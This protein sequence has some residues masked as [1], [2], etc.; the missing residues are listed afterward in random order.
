MC[1]TAIRKLNN[2]NQVVAMWNFGKYKTIVV[3]IALF[4]LLDASVLILNFYIS[5][6]ISDDAVGVN[7][8]GRQRMLSQ[9]MV[10]SL[11]DIE[12]L[13]DQ[14]DLSIKALTELDSTVNLFDKT[15]DAFENG[16]VTTDPSSNQVKISKVTDRKGRE[17][18]EK[19]RKLWTPYEKTLTPLIQNIKENG[20]TFD[21]QEPIEYARS[22]NL[23]LLKY[24]NDLTV[25]LENV[26]SSKAT[27]LR[28][29]QTIGISLAILN[30]FIIMFHF[31]KQLRESDKKIDA[32]RKETTEI[33]GTVNEGL[34]LLDQ[35]LKI[36]SQHSTQLIE[37]FNRKRFEGVSFEELLRDIVTSKTLETSKRFINLFYRED[38]NSSLIKDLNPL[39]KV[40]LSFVSEEGNYITKFFSFSFSRVYDIENKITS[41]LTTVV[42]ITEKV[43]L[44]KELAH[45]QKASEQQ[46]ELLTDIL[47]TDSN[48]VNS[49]LSRCFTEYKNINT[50]LKRT[51]RTKESL[52]QNLDKTFTIL[53]GIK[54][55]AGALGLEGFTNIIHK[56]ED[57]IRSLQDLKELN[58]NDLLPLIV[59]FESLIRYTE[60]IQHLTG[61]LKGFS[62]HN[63][64][65]PHEA[66][67]SN[68]KP[69]YYLTDFCKRIAQDN[70]KSVQ[71][72]T[73]GM[74][75]TPIDDSLNDNITTI[76]TQCIRNSI[77]H[78][79]ETPEE[80]HKLGK[81]EQGR[82]DVNLATLEN[83]I[84]EL[85]ISDDG[86]GFDFDGI[87][88]K[89]K[90]TGQ[91]PEEVID[92]WDK[93][94]LVSV[95]FNNGFSTADELTNDAGRG[96]G[97]NV[98]REKIRD[99]D[100]KIFLSS[101]KNSYS[102]L[103]ITMPYKINSQKVA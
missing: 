79:I 15:L 97:M 68:E 34:F 90:K 83:D 94:K 58:G 10:K 14:P 9:R 6:E 28:I 51:A 47:N 72:V 103:I 4:L 35:D 25:A 93:K 19:A 7:L 2:A 88:N 98:I 70:N 22:N 80:R 99:I 65:S 61:K 86:K 73:S 13:K 11:L 85:S 62:K 24:M 63:T 91:W 60:S 26:A 66:S 1:F 101:R 54:G 57:N 89:A 3:S 17:A 69:G 67:N 81:P 75:E 27:T 39:S 77:V 48:I 45:S 46:L 43:Y 42:D 36:G 87:K 32:A 53:H 92:K 76:I 78:G 38:I 40:E 44:E 30:F 74:H 82:I 31:L 59:E 8:A 49:F 37:M 55:D 29:I 23:L 102:K 96:M 56:I 52:L 21:L 100:G 5:F 50:H 71:L 84:L 16:G 33:L 20:G 64:N 18:I 95:A 12:Y 41:I